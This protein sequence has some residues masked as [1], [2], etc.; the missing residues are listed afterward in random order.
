MQR[1]EKHA[2]AVRQRA[3]SSS[4]VMAP[5]HWHFCY[6]ESKSAREE[7]NLRVKS[8]ALDFLQR[9]DCLRG[10]SSERLEAALCVLEIQ[11][12]QDSEK[13]VECSSEDLACQRLA[14]RLQFAAHPARTDGDISP[15]FERFEKLG[16]F[17]NRG[18]QIGIGENNDRAAR[19]KNPIANAVPLSVVTRVLQ[20][21]QDRIILNIA[22]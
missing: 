9:E 7:E 14:M 5:N 13:K 15:T 10:A 19:M 16:C 2:G 21:P 3:N 17:F 18:R 4:G 8:P 6:F 11:A 1:L 20:Q 12:Q 22:A